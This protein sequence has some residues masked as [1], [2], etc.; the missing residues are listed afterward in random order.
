[1]QIPYNMQMNFNRKKFNNLKGF[2][3]FLTNIVN[4][5]ILLFV[6]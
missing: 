3:V 6:L 2:P 4:I 1:M 5:A